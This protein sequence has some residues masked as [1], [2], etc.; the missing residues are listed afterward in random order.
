M[1]HVVGDRA[2]GAQPWEVLVGNLDL[3]SIFDFKKQFDNS[4]RIESQVVPQMVRFRDGRGVSFQIGGKGLNDL[5]SNREF[6]HY[7]CSFVELKFPAAN[8][9]IGVS[10]LQS[11]S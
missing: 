11:D 6:G 3:K 1:L 4:D 7:G 2:D 8:C 5:G 9:G 10:V